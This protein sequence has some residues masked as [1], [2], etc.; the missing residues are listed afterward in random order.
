MSQHLA[1][2]LPGKPGGG[3]LRVWLKS[4][5][6]TRKLLLGDGGDPWIDPAGYLA[7]F[8]Q[9]H[10]LLRPDVAVL[11]VGELFDSWVQRNPT[12]KAELDAK[13]RAAYPLRR[14]LELSEPRDMLA[15][16]VDAVIGNLRGQ[17]PLVLSM[18]SPALWL[19]QAAAL[20]GRG[21]TPPDPETID[22]AAMYVADLLRAV[23]SFPVGGVMLEEHPDDDQMD[24]I[25][26]ERY[27][28]LI[29]V[30]A[31]Y[32]W[33]LVLRPGRGGVAECATLTAFDAV[34]SQT[35]RVVVPASTG[36]DISE[37]LWSDDVPPTLAQGQFYFVE[38]PATQR[39]ELVLEKI[40]QLRS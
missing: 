15:Q 7:Y 29:N 28:P 26:L 12:V 18:P 2:S 34:I 17:T 14:L 24:E 13:R 27:R 30:A 4:S 8:S 9:A 16:V 40:A 19:R 1:D 37:R 10:G 3:G 22:D 23:S 38:I 39:P 31:H 32:R 36:V 25:A 33:S 20:A 5:A 11:E 6:Y 21:D 35:C